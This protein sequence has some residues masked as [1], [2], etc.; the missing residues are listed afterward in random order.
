MDAAMRSAVWKSASFSSTLTTCIC[1][2]SKGTARSTSAP[3]GILAV[4]G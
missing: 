2:S 1:F 3:P 4:V